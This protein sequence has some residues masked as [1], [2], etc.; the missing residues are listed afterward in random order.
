[1]KKIYIKTFGC[2]Q[3]RADSERIK[4]YYWNEGY[5]LTNKLEEADLVVI[6]TCVIRESAENRAYG[7]INQLKVKSYKLKVV[8]TGCLVGT[9]IRQ[10]KIRALKAKF[11]EVNEFLPITKFDYPNPPLRDKTKAAMIP[12]SSGCNHFCSYCIVPFAR[13]QEISRDIEGILK[14]VDWA[15][16]DGFKEVVL[17]G[18]SVNSYNDGKFF[19]LLEKV[20]KKPLEKVS[21]ISSNPWDFSDELIKV[22]AKYKNIDRLIHLPIQSG[23]D[24]ILKKMNRGYTRAFYL[25]LVDKIKKE[26]EGVR[27]ST[28]IIV[29]FPGEDE[30]AFQNTVKL[31]EKVNFDIAY[32]NKYSPRRG[33]VSAKIYADDVPMAEKKRRWMVLEK[34]VNEKELL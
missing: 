1:V 34:L 31:C 26:I 18:Q 9:A 15:I 2:V 8:V 7:L 20:A 19:E 5:E 17:I 3:N 22:I 21:F 10:K 11:P 13:G 28:D 27:I 4:S 33:T 32:I 12:I 6:N 24:E 30:K 29:G 14:E 16:K 25:K 23:D